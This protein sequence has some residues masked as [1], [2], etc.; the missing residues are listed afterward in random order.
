M[1]AGSS[2]A[3][4][5][6]AGDVFAPLSTEGR[7]DV[8]IDGGRVAIHDIYESLRLPVWVSHGTRGDFA[9]YQQL[10]GF[11]TRGNW[12]VTVFDTGAMPHLENAPRF[13]EQFD[14]FLAQPMR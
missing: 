13:T 12:R 11:A 7:D 8:S 6:L 4:H 9:D 1:D 14:A 3:D 2:F 10:P 5:S